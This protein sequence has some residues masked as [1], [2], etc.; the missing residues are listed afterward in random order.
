MNI[1]IVWNVNLLARG[2]PIAQINIDGVYLVVE[3]GLPSVHPTACLFA[4][5]T[6]RHTF[7]DVHSN[8]RVIE[9]FLHP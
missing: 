3:H 4:K 5:T 9:D 8:E 1:K 2:N 7:V 6:S